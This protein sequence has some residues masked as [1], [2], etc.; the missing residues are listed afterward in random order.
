MSRRGE[1]GA[2][3]EGRPLGYGEGGDL[4]GRSRCEEISRWRR[5]LLKR[6]RD[7]CV[8]HVDARFGFVQRSLRACETDRVHTSKGATEKV[9]PTHKAM[10]KILHATSCHVAPEQRR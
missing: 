2:Y 6:A 3:E 1:E 5:L 9:K 8:G 10:V 4:S 7:L